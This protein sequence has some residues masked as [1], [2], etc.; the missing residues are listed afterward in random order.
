MGFNHEFGQAFRACKG[1]CSARGGPGEAGDFYGNIFGSGLCFSKTA[2]GDF[3][4]GID[5][6]RDDSIEGN[7][8]SGQDFGG[9]FALVRGFVGQAGSGNDV[10]DGED[11]FVHFSA[12]K[13]DGYKTLQ[14]GEDVEFEVSNGDKGLHADNVTKLP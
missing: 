10:T 11:V 7:G 1:G 2:P 13:A 9:N 4:V 8:F 12:I 6:G 3:R 14:E 5:H